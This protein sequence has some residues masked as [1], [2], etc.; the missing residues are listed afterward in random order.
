MLIL[1]FSTRILNGYLNPKTVKGGM[2][3]FLLSG[4]PILQALVVFLWLVIDRG[5][6]ANFRSGCLKWVYGVARTNILWELS[7][8]LNLLLGI[9]LHQ[10]GCQWVLWLNGHPHKGIKRMGLQRGLFGKSKRV[11]KRCS[12]IFRRWDTLLCSVLQF[13]SAVWTTFVLP[14]TISRLFSSPVELRETWWLGTR[15]GIMLLH[16]LDVRF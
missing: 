4:N 3:S 2:W 6:T 14:T 1:V 15:P 13:C 8:M 10:Q 7:R 5:I 9:S 16:C 12:S 11:W